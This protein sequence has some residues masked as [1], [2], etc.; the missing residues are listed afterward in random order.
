MPVTSNDPRPPYL[1]VADD[2]RDAIVSGRYQAG[3]RLPSGRDLAKEYGVALMTMQ[4][5][6]TT[7]ASEGFVVSYQ[8]RG[9]F[10]RTPGEVDNPEAAQPNTD[11]NLEAV[12][13]RLRKLEER[14]RKLERV[15]GSTSRRRSAS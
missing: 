14:V 10:V 4:K 5:A 15:S 13:E 12:Q 2:L 11:T 9:V 3:E 8:G 1:Q 6:L 7:L